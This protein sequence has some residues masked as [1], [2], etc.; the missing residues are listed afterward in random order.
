[1]STDISILENFF[2][3]KENGVIENYNII[4]SNEAIYLVNSSNNYG[5]FAKS[6]FSGI[7]DVAG[8][9]GDAIG[10]VGGLASEL[11][12]NKLSKMF[13]KISDDRSQAKLN[14]V[15]KNLDKYAANK[16]GVDKIELEQLLKLVVKKGMILNGKSYA[17]FHLQDTVHKLF[18]K[19]RADIAALIKA[20]QTQG[21]A[22]QVVSKFL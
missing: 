16:K 15:L 19:K 17:E 12:G 10:I 8:L 18:S 2:R 5:K 9:F 7:G 22:I 20:I 4:I 13:G 1:M 6:I 14:K 21:L 3:E 11:T